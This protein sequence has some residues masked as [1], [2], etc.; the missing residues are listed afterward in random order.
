MARGEL[1]PREIEIISLVG[2]GQTSKDVGRTLGISPRT[3]DA[4]LVSAKIKTNSRN[5]PHLI[6]NTMRLISEPMVEPVG[7]EPT[8]S[9]FQTAALT[10]SATVPSLDH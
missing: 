2:Q 3:V 1:T 6:T 4:H 8:S 7:I 9:A 10:N 5:K